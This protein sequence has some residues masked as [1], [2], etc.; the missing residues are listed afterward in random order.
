[1]LCSE[2]LRPQL[3][4]GYGASLGQRW[5]VSCPQWVIPGSCMFP[6]ASNWREVLLAQEGSV[7]G[8]SAAERKQL[9]S[10]RGPDEG[11][12]KVRLRGVP[13][14]RLSNLPI[15]KTWCLAKVE[16]PK[17]SEQGEGGGYNGPNRGLVTKLSLHVKVLIMI[18]PGTLLTRYEHIHTIVFV[19]A[20]SDKFPNKR[21][22]SCFFIY[23]I[24]FFRLVK[25]HRQERSNVFH[26][27]SSLL[28]PLDLLNVAI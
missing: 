10:L 8:P 22:R 24:Y 14:S 21:I 19:C 15:R 26:S 13:W 17:E 3:K 12:M 16:A 1:M 6:N 28:L 9:L 2:E 27:T 7:V 4:L 11:S 5:C 18:L 25:S 20:N 23:G